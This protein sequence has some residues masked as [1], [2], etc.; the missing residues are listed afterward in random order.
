M[1]RGQTQV[2]HKKIQALDALDGV[3]NKNRAKQYTQPVKAIV[4]VC[5]AFPGHNFSAMPGHSRSA[6]QTGG[7]THLFCQN[8]GP[9]LRQVLKYLQRIWKI[10]RDLQRTRAYPESADTPICCSPHRNATPA[11][12]E[13]IVELR[14]LVYGFV[15]NKVLHTAKKKLPS[16]IALREMASLDP[17]QTELLQALFAITKSAQDA[18]HESFRSATESARYKTGALQARAQ[19]LLPPNRE[20]PS[21]SP[22]FTPFK[23]QWTHPGFDLQKW[24]SKLLKVEAALATLHTAAVSLRHSLCASSSSTPSSIT[25]RRWGRSVRFRFEVIIVS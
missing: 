18:D 22:K 17:A 19:A 3:L 13:I 4:T 11:E 16:S 14:D 12:L 23:T 5:T 15:A 24:T 2:R 20:R 9:E 6:T 25:P 1:E 10:L 21:S 7:Q 8:G